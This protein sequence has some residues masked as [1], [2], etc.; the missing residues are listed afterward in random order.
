MLG[1]CPVLSSTTHTTYNV[2]RG[3][4]VGLVI[5]GL[6][7]RC[8]IAVA[9]PDSPPLI[10]QA[11]SY[12]LNIERSSLNVALRNLGLQTG[13]QIGQRAE[14]LPSVGLV[15]PLTGVYTREQALIALL[16]GTGLSYRFVNERT[17]AIVAADS[18]KESEPPHHDAAPKASAPAGRTGEGRAAEQ[19]PPVPRKGVLGRIIAAVAACGLFSGGSVCAQEAAGDAGGGA[20][21]PHT[22]L[23]EII[24]TARRREERLQDVP[25]SMTVFDQQ[26]LA[27]RNVVNIDD[28]ATYTP[29]L[30][31]NGRFGSNSSSIAIRGFIQEGPTSPSVGIYFADVIAPRADGG[32]TAGN[33]SNPG[34][35][36]DLQN[37][38]VLKGPQGTL[39]GRNTTGGAVLIVPQKPTSELGGYV[40]ASAGNYDMWRTQ[41]VLNVPINDAIRIRLGVDHESRDGYLRNISFVPGAPLV[42]PKD[43]DDVD[44]TALRLSVV[45]DLTPNLENYAIASFSVSDTNGS[46]PKMIYAAPTGYRAANYAAQVAALS[47]DYYDVSNGNPFAGEKIRQWQLINTTTWNPI[48]SLT[49]KNITSYAQF[50]QRQ[51]EAIYG[52]NGITLGDPI[53]YNSSVDITPLPRKYNVSQSTFTE[54]LQLQGHPNERLN[55]QAGGYAEFSEPLNGFQTTYSGGFTDCVNIL[56]LECTDTR[57]LN[58]PNG[59]GGNLQGRIGSVAKS[60]TQYHFRNLGVFAQAT[61]KIF[62]PLSLTGGIRYTSDY[63]SGL[64]ESIKI[65]FPAPNTPS[66]TC[67]NPLGLVLGGTSA[68]ILADPSRC[69]LSRNASSSKPTWLVDLDYKPIDDVLLYAKYSRGYRQGSVNVSSYG[70]ETWGPEKVDTYEVGTK[71]SFDAIV[72][73]IFNLALFYNDFSNQQLQLGTV[74]CTTISLP[75][76]PFVPAAAAGIANAGKS[77]IRGLETETTLNL[78]RGVNLDLNYSYLD[79]RIE[80]ITIPPPPLGFTSLQTAPAGG[81]IPL[82]PRHKYAATLSY[83]LPLTDALGDVTAAATLTHQ[84]QYFGSVSSARSGLTGIAGQTLLNLNLN[85]ESVAHLPLDLSFFA[86]NVT[87]KKYYTFTTGASFGFD[88]AII[89]EPRMYGARVRYRFGK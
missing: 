44:Y 69:D 22:E 42:G 66:Y 20:A 3:C 87:R 84:T 55:Y 17:V 53:H 60:Q 77:M 45:A 19:V 78:F 36:F 7:P 65:L 35:F 51:A 64:G 88:S 68:Q 58:T 89:A 47:H 50:W 31:S 23:T 39:F 83:K 5:L 6:V 18:P 9:A 67:S 40:E 25:I 85:W 48:D 8:V 62:E 49:V 28:L 10:T 37:V 14:V 38:Q 80:S 82:T 24:V 34:S 86:T 71:T 59:A 73:G 26:Q 56:A 12:H 2:V 15:G 32:T 57:G 76:C 79:T 21:V 27:D 33:G 75:Q 52:D 70:L 29:S 16:R 61:Y 54:E 43:F 13:L 1:T 63:T 30:S 11:V 41:G 72:R 81:P 46:L 74:P 4:L